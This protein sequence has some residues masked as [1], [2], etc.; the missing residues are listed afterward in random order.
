MLLDSSQFTCVG[1]DKFHTNPPQHM[2]IDANPTTSKQGLTGFL[3]VTPIIS[4][5]T[6]FKKPARA[7]HGDLSSFNK[8]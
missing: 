7:K 4:Y 3:N 1:V 8:N 6:G 2:W 5:G